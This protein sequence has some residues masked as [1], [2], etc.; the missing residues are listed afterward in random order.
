MSSFSN[1]GITGRLPWTPSIFMVLGLWVLTLIL[2]HQPTYPLIYLPS[3]GLPFNPQF[4]AISWA[5]YLPFSSEVYNAVHAPVYWIG[6]FMLSRISMKWAWEHEVKTL[7]TM[8]PIF[9]VIYCS[10]IWGAVFCVAYLTKTG[11]SCQNSQGYHLKG[12]GSVL[13]HFF[14]HT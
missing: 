4:A 7:Y 5:F 3:P 2:Q 1:V 9:L 14:F 10:P 13:W 6:L 11:D 12:F 8:S